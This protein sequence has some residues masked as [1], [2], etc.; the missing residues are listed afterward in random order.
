M[1]KNEVI[2]SI[3]AQIPDAYEG[4][5]LKLVPDDLEWERNRDINPLQFRALGPRG[6]VHYIGVATQVGLR[7]I[8]YGPKG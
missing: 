7:V 1:T 5:T 4:E 8:S 6:G 3:Q 2:K